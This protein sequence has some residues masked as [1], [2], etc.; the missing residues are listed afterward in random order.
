M[1]FIDEH[2]D[3][4]T[5]GLRW[6]VEPICAELTKHGCGIAPSTY[7]AAKTRPPSPRSVRDAVVLE[8]VR[9]VHASPMI[10]RRVWRSE[11][12]ARTRP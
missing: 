10:G 12:V 5:A 3:R 11:G 4:Q 9:R 7:Y 6:G 1:R 8:H 2:R